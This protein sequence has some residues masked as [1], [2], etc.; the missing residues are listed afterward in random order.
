MINPNED[1][2]ARTNKLAM[3]LK[4]K[5]CNLGSERENRI[6][7]IVIFVVVIAVVMTA[8]VPEMMD[9][10]LKIRNFNEKSAYLAIFSGII[11]LT[12]I[13]LGFT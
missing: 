11:L 3:V 10:L 1:A 12:I 5:W 2:D 7:L 6:C 8:R 4:E 9:G 13:I